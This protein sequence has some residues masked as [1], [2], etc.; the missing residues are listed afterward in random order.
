MRN[1]PLY[2]FSFAKKSELGETVTCF[3]Q[4]RISQGKKYETV[5]PTDSTKRSIVKWSSQKT[6]NI[7]LMFV[8]ITKARQWCRIIASQGFSGN[9]S[10]LISFLQ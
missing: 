2:F 9:I 1:E 4:L 5:N 8:S 3:V 7:L 10:C 6:S